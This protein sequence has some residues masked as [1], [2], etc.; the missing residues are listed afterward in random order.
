[1]TRKATKMTTRKVTECR[2]TGS[3]KARAPEE[4]IRARAYEICLARKGE[5]GDALSD[6]FQAERELNGV[7]EDT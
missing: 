2:P 1:M 6:W 7:T 4:K 5:P 3:E